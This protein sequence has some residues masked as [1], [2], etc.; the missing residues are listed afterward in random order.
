MNFRL[1]YGP[2]SIRLGLFT[3]LAVLAAIAAYFG[4]KLVWPNVSIHSLLGL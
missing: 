3:V 1:G 4:G 2:V